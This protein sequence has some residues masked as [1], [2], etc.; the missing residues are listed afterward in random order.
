MNLQNIDRRIIYL[1]LLVVAVVPLLVEK[2]PAVKRVVPELPV[3]ISNE[4]QQAYDTIENMP[5]NKIAIISII[6]SASTVPENQPQTEVLA[7]HLFRRGVPFVIIPFDQQGTTL[8]YNAVE[9]IAK[10]MHK[11]YGKDWMALGFQPGGYM[12]QIIQ[13]MGV[14]FAG[15]FKKDRNGTPIADVPMMKGMNTARNIGLVV[16]VTPSATVP[17]WIAFM[18][19]PYRV[20]IVYCPTSVMIPEAHNYLDAHQVA[21]MLPGVI[22]AAQYEEK[23]G[24]RG[25]GLRAAG[26]LSAA[27]LLIILLI[28]LGNMGYLL[29]RRRNAGS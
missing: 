8:A 10:E 26:P 14:D 22:G 17:F 24:V 28:V 23:L 12:V 2:I 6:W 9:R 19:Q 11:E 20:P 7:R 16:E 15:Q 4:V 3:P 1:L 21:G 29:S 27:H 13:G 5:A 18:G 25:F